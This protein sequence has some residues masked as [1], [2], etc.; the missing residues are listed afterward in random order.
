MGSSPCRC[1]LTPRIALLA[2][3]FHEV[4]GAARTC[5]ELA[6]F[7]ERRG[8]AFLTV[9]FSTGEPS[10][11][12]RLELRRSRLALRVD[13]DLYFDPIFYRQLD[14]V[15]K[16]LRDFQPDLIHITSPGDAGILGAILAHKLGLPLAASWHTNL[17]EFAARRVEN[18]L[19]WAPRRLRTGVAARVERFVLDRVLWFFSRA[20]LAFAPNRELIS[21]VARRS[22]RPVFPMRRGID[23]NLFTPA[24]RT[25]KDGGVVLG[26]VGRLMPEKRV[27]FL[28]ELERFLVRA[29]VRDFRFLIVGS[30]SE[31][32]WLERAVERAEFTGVLTGEAL[33]TA[34]ASM[35][36]FVFPSETDTFGNVVQEA[37][38]SGVPAV[39]S[40]KGGP[41]FVVADGADGFVA[42]GDGEFCAAV[43]RL[44]RDASLRRVMA[45]AAVAEMA[46]RSWDRVFE[47]VYD[48][49]AA[50]LRDRRPAAETS[51]S[52]S[53][54]SAGAVLWRLLSRP[55]DFLVRKWNWK[56]AVLSAVSR[57]CLFFLMNLGAG[58]KKA[59]G[60]MVTELVLRALTAG[61]FGS[62]SQAFSGVRPLWKAVAVVVPLVAVCQHP[63]ELLV[64][65]LRGT[66]RLPAS[67]AASV[68]FTALSNAA[69]L[70]LMRKGALVVGAEG[71]PLWEDL[72]TIPG[73]MRELCKA[74]GDGF[75]RVVAGWQREAERP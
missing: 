59:V 6:V 52:L 4:N 19:E 50:V 35:D 74:T 48:G 25:R 57:C 45:E 31:H 18:L 49:Y 33:A 54:P 63:L 5:R 39:V 24:R 62:V 68:V 22:G 13:P 11:E 46:L 66:P 27:R 64:H 70:A 73:L 67:I 55:Q 7:A 12:R 36:V 3:T 43:E 53:G 72:A 8:Y 34:Y 28:A 30:G 1:S 10:T 2:D 29:G 23:T 9:C 32:P 75:K 40:D 56:S 38:A 71:R 37:L 51:D 65:W 17:H 16:E 69:E 21:L 26:Y 42:G 58:W 14:R 41:R 60:A 44:A 15:E 47:E 20:D 61:W